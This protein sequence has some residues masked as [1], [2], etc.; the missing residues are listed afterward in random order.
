MPKDHLSHAEKTRKIFGATINGWTVWD[1]EPLPGKVWKVI[2]VCLCG[3]EKAVDGLAL[4]SGKTK[5]CFSCACKGVNRNTQRKADIYPGDVFGDWTVLHR[6][7]TRQRATY[8]CKCKCGNESI[9]GRYA[10]SR[11]QSQRCNTCRQIK[12]RTPVEG[13][14]W[15]RILRSAEIRSWKVVLTQEDAFEL[16]KK[17][18]YKCALSGEPIAVDRDNPGTT[19]SLDRID[20]TQDYSLSNVQWVHKYVNLMKQSF[21]QEYFI[22]ICKKVAAHNDV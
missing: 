5:R 21:S 8:V 13:I 10:L 18:E 1:D 16:L 19:A 11:K 3:K 7:E 12:S 9:V 2:A 6:T 20:S 14:V 17:Q 22:S 4:V 15:R